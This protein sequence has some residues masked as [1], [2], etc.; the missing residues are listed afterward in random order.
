MSHFEPRCIIIAINGFTEAIYVRTFRRVV[1][2]IDVIVRVLSPI[3]GAITLAMLPQHILSFF[4]L[5]IR[6]NADSGSGMCVGHHPQATYFNGKNTVRP[7]SLRMDKADAELYMTGWHCSSCFGYVPLSSY[8][9]YSAAQIE[10][11]YGCGLKEGSITTFKNRFV[12][13]KTDHGSIERLPSASRTSSSHEPATVLRGNPNLSWTYSFLDQNRAGNMELEW[14]EE[15]RAC[16]AAVPF[17]T[18]LSPA[19]SADS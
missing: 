8:L 18:L 11:K 15:S 14:R 10:S 5:P 2:P 4:L 3:V 6:R 19:S 9:F 1:F 7:E 12:S 17:R 16:R 13:P